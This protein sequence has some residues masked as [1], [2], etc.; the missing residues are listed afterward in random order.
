MAS[1]PAS[2]GARPCAASRVPPPVKRR[3]NLALACAQAFLRVEVELAG[4]VGE[5]EQQ[6]ADLIG[7]PGRVR[8]RGSSARSSP[9]SSSSLSSTARG[10]RPVEA[11]PG[12]AARSAW[13]RG[14]GGQADGDAG[15]ACRSRP[16]RPAR[17]PSAPPRPRSAPRHRGPR[18][19]RRHADGGR[20]S[21]RRWSP[22]RRRRRNCR[23]PRP[24]ARGRRPGT[25]GRP[26]RPAAPAKSP[27][28]IASATS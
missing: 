11:D 22:R 21:C 20:P 3:S 18:R 1:S 27:R 16:V 23:P 24:S 9:T 13:R 25:A 26:V 17:R 14:Q 4:Q 15:Q 7:Q 5:H 2:P 19:R 6:V 12:G 8:R 10:V 28:A